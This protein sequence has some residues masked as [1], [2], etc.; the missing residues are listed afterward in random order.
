MRH[1]RAALLQA[2]RC[3]HWAHKVFF[4]CSFI[5]SNAFLKG[6]FHSALLLFYTCCCTPSCFLMDL[7]WSLRG[8]CCTWS[9]KGVLQEL[10]TADCVMHLSFSRS[11]S[12]NLLN[13]GWLFPPALSCSG[14]QSLIFESAW[15]SGMPKTEPLT[16]VYRD[17][18]ETKAG[19]AASSV[20]CTG[21]Q[22][23]VQ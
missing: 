4:P 5:H 8:C 22:H 18:P 3:L 17:C 7:F 2:E 21:S 15:T 10:L 16:Y 9:R 19:R 13:W 23:D 6:I 14:N 11:L 12:M 20:L 1:R